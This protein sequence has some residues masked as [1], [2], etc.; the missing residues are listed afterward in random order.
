VEKVIRQPVEEFRKTMPGGS[1][2]EQIDAIAQKIAADEKISLPVARARAWDRN[3]KLLAMYN[4]AKAQP[5]H[6]QVGG[7]RC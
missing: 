3:P 4:A 5:T 6:R 2:V 7:G 1:A